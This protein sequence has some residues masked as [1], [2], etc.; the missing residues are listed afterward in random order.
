MSVTKH[1]VERNSRTETEIGSGRIT[2][3]SVTAA[4]EHNQSEIAIH[5]LL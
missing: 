2:G 3:V 5:Y 1:S 4:N